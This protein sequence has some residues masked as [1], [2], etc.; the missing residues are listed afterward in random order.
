MNETKVVISKDARIGAESL[1]N[2][3]RQGNE[4]SQMPIAGKKVPIYI[5][6]SSDYEKQKY[7][8]FLQFCESR[9]GKLIMEKENIE[10]RDK[11][12]SKRLHK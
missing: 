12:F 6:D 4:V 10:S 5:K 7:L 3:M 9:I 11:G 8:S 1:I 2:Q